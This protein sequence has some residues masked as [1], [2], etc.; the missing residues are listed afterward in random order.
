MNDFS[1]EDIIKVCG[2]QEIKK[3]QRQKQVKENKKK[4]YEKNC[5][6]DFYC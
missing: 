5:K 1:L 4:N 2:E 6:F 3:R